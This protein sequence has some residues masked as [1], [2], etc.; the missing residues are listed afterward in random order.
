MP[1]TGTGD[2][3]ICLTHACLGAGTHRGNCKMNGD[4][5]AW[6]VL[7]REKHSGDLPLPGEL[8]IAYQSGGCT[9]LCLGDFTTEERGV[10]TV[11]T[12][13]GSPD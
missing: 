3:E 4:R 13:A 11:W 9:E 7:R 12:E 1:G 6:S 8:A 5:S 2:R 10:R